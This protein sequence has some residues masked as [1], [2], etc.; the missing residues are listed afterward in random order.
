MNSAGKI[1]GIDFSI[2]GPVEK[3]FDPNTDG[4]LLHV[5]GKTHG[6]LPTQAQAEQMR[7]EL[8]AHLAQQ[9]KTAANWGGKR[10]GAGRPRRNPTMTVEL[11]ERATR[12]LAYFIEDLNLRPQEARLIVSTILSTALTDDLDR[13]RDLFGNRLIQDE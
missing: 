7:D 1:K 8:I 9:K 6:Y 12:D 10:P 5:D 4:W 2:T 11:T 13:W 3:A